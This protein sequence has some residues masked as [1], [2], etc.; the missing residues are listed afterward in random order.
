M[1]LLACSQNWKEK[2]L[3]ICKYPQILQFT[4][5]QD[6]L[7]CKL[8]GKR[9]CRSRG[10]AKPAAAAA[11]VV[12]PE[13]SLHADSNT[14]RPFPPRRGSSAI[15]LESVWPTARVPLPNAA[16]ATTTNERLRR[17]LLAPGRDGGRGARSALLRGGAQESRI[18]AAS[19][20]C[21]EFQKFRIFRVAVIWTKVSHRTALENN[22]TYISHTINLQKNLHERRLRLNF[23]PSLIKNSRIAYFDFASPILILRFPMISFLCCITCNPPQLED[24]FGSRGTGHLQTWLPL[25]E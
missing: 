24:F 1:L 7:F 12:Q 4:A 16:A 19:S 20:W 13:S 18:R 22:G 10:N 2:Q 23:I 3:Q 11:A 6:G 8:P 17:A 14:G 21:W 9:P 5:A 15:T 25:R